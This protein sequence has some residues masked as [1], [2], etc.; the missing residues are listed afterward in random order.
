MLL[1][2]S[3][4]KMLNLFQRLGKAVEALRTDKESV[5]NYFDA[6][7]CLFKRVGRDRTSQVSQAFERAGG[8]DL[9]E[10]FQAQSQNEEISEV[11]R[12]I[13]REFFEEANQME[14]HAIGETVNQ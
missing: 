3:S 7:M 2:P 4:D 11:C 12:E 10:S 1:V 9:L 8:L 5:K 6:V 14:D 13:I